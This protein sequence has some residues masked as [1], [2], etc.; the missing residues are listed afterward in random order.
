MR[1]K[2]ED[3]F[4]LIIGDKLIYTVAD[5]KLHFDK[6]VKIG[7]ITHWLKEEVKRIGYDP[8]EYLF[9]VKPEVLPT[10]PVMDAYL[11]LGQLKDQEKISWRDLI[12]QEIERIANKPVKSIYNPSEDMISVW[13]EAA[14]AL[15]TASQEFLIDVLKLA[16]SYADKRGSDTVTE[17]DLHKAAEEFIK[18]DLT[19]EEEVEI[20]NPENVQ[21]SSL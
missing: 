6:S 10:L 3:K 1:K 16:N 4:A 13:K 14:E 9:E 19:G 8:R 11:E 20:G 7:R 18:D 12:L 17:L 21:D 15:E 5:S 2:P